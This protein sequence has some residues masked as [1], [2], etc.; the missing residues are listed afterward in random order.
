MVYEILCNPRSQADSEEKSEAAGLLAQITSPWLDP[1]MD[2]AQTDGLCGDFQPQR[3]VTSNGS[4]PTLQ[5]TPYISSFVAALTG[6]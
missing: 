3:P 6:K 4:W 2:E 1:P 5:L